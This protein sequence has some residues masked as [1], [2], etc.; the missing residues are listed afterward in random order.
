M[1]NIIID[2]SDL[3]DPCPQVVLVGGNCYKFL[4][5]NDKT[6]TT[7][8]PTSE[9]STCDYCEA[10]S[11]EYS[12][13]DT[14]ANKIYVDPSI[15]ST[16]NPPPGT[17]EISN[18]CYET[19]V[20]SATA[21]DTFS[22]DSEPVDCEDGDCSPAP[23]TC[24]FDCGDGMGGA[25]PCN[26]SYTATVT[27]VPSLAIGGCFGAADCDDFNVARGLSYG[28]LCQ[29]NSTFPGTMVLNCFNGG[30]NTDWEVKVTCGGTV[31]RWTAPNPGSPSCPP[32]T[33]WAFDA[34]ASTCG[35]GTLVLS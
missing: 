27:G 17:V 8:A 14:P 28:G 20:A 7:G 19:P 2:K 32:L 3:S 31:L 26:M 1:A 33:G 6:P 13:C 5:E 10:I 23:V 4:E 22:I 9:L 12:E 24:P 18:T 11:I 16:L 29:W 34:G 30:G 25:A 21:I 15:L 35:S